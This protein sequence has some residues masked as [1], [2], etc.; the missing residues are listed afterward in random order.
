MISTKKLKIFLGKNFGFTPQERLIIYI[1]GFA[2]ALGI[3]LNIW[4]RSST[5][6]V[7]SAQFTYTQ[8]DSI[9]TTLSSAASRDGADLYGKNP[10]EEAYLLKQINVMTESDF[11]ALPGIGPV[12]SKRIVQFRTTHGGFAAFDNILAVPGI[13]TKRLE[14]IRECLLENYKK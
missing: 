13:G 2:I 6:D 14:V 8:L 4:S 5:P 7:S 11:E 10:A 9:F 3:F 12:L 1:L